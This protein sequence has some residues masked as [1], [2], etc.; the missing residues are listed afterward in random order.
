MTRLTQRAFWTLVSSAWR[1]LAGSAWRRRGLR[2]AAIG[3]GILVGFPGFKSLFVIMR[4]LGFHASWLNHVAVA[5]AVL[6]ALC[7]AMMSQATWGPHVSA[8]RVWV[9][10][11]LQYRRLHPLWT[12][13]TAEF[14]ELVLDPPPRSRLAE[15]IAVRG[16]KYRLFRR[17]VEIRDGRIV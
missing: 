6:G 8:A 7:T 2:A 1:W 10:Q 11:L 5:C 15:L 12:A 4:L 16:L 13:I 9:T 3:C 14:P 17:Y